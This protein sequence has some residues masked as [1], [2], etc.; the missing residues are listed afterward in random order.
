[1]ASKKRVV[2]GITTS[3]KLHLGNY[4][5]ALRQFIALQR[6][7]DGYFFLADL[8]ALATIHDPSKL[9]TNVQSIAT[10][11]LACGLDPHRATFFRQSDVSEH[12]EL[13][14]MLNTI[15]TMGELSRM[16]QFKDKSGKTSKD[17]I[18]AGLF[19]YPTLM[20]ADILLYQPELVPVGDDQKQHIELTRT[21]AERFNKRFVRTFTVPDI[22]MPK[23]GARIM[24]LDDPAQK[25]SKSAT[26]EYNYIALAD[27]PD[28]IAKK[29]K[30]AVTD[31]GKEVAASNHGPALKNLLTI[32]SALS[33]EPFKIVAERFTG[34][35][36][37]DFKNALTERIVESLKPIQSRLRELEQ[38]SS[39]VDQILKD[40]ADKARLVAAKTLADAKS[41]MGLS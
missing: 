35:S 14:W 11:Y 19:N 13:A 30:K 26:S 1:M 5:G 24:G 38:D 3:G 7:Y 15:S 34:T 17:S 27:S 31:S 36:Y 8:H 16:T 2:S 12:A 37:G 29:I 32:Y 23:E 4:I 33:D 18:Q 39:A 40:G 22:L 10:L 20:A 28:V 41:A 25:M 21:L 6:E 9:R